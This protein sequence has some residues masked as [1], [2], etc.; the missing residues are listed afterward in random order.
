MLVC[1]GYTPSLVN[2]GN[3]SIALTMTILYACIMPTRI[4]TNK[5]RASA[6]YFKE[7]CPL[8]ICSDRVDGV[9]IYTHNKYMECNE[10]GHK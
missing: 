6:R 8:F 5:T 3:P 9:Y 10:K 2:T 4:A 7:G 1:L